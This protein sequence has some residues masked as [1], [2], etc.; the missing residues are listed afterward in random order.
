[1]HRKGGNGPQGHHPFTDV[2]AAPRP[3]VQPAEAR[4]YRARPMRPFTIMTIAGL[5]AAAAL[6]GCAGSDDKQP[7][8]ASGHDQDGILAT[9]DAL[10]TASRAGDGATVCSRVFTAGLVRSIERTSKRSC[11]KEV[12][13]NL[14]RRDAAYS[15]QRNITADGD[16]GSATIREQNGNVSTLHLVQQAGVWRIDRVTPQH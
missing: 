12:K 11:A 3:F 2:N 7:T 9:V 6:S 4:K 10:Q 1:M 5:L 16:A 13:K 15:L 8:R 14:F